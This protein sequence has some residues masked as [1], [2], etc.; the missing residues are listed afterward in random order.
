[1]KFHAAIQQNGKTATGIS[2]PPGVI[3]SL[4]TSKKPAVRVTIK[5]YTFRTTIGVLGGEFKIPVSEEV[6]RK[7]GVAAGD[8]VDIEIELDNEPRIVSVPPDLASA[9]D[10][11]ADARRFFDGLSYSNQRRFVMGIDEAKSPESRQ[12]RIAK[13]ISMLHE[14]RVDNAAAKT[15]PRRER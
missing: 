11:D 9:L 6:R 8:E 12:R 1:M 10:Q 7:A 15:E 14:G 3:A 13:T 5:E 4:G 2:V